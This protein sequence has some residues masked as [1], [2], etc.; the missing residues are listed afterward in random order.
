M[1]IRDSTEGANSGIKY[2]VDPELNKGPGSAIGLEFQILD[3]QRHPD[4][5][6]GVS[7]NRTLGSLYDLIT[8]DDLSNITSRKN[9]IFKGVGSWNK[10]RIVVQDGHVEHWLNDIKVVE[11]DRH[12]QVF[13]ALVQYSKYAKWPNFGQ[14]PEGNILLQDHGDTVHYRSIK[15]RELAP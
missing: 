8:M 7:G 5:K 10:A 11:F 4:A 14:L 6:A 2:F 9:K 15:I 1:C 3:D 12:S 13:K